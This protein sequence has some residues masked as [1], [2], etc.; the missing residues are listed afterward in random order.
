MHELRV[1]VLAGQAARLCDDGSGTL[2][3]MRSA[4][5]SRIHEKY[6]SHHVISERCAC[7]CAHKRLTIEG[8]KGTRASPG[9]AIIRSR[10]SNLCSSW[11]CHGSGLHLRI[12]RCCCLNLRA[13]QYTSPA[14]FALV[15]I[16][17]SAVGHFKRMTITIVICGIC[18]LS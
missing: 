5:E 12:R 15:D 3:P 6:V 7:S 1:D 16:R 13:C 14:P 2:G 4:P 9:N 10:M 17:H 11:M 18:T 8:A